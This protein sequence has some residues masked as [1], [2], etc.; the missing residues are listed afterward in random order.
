MANLTTTISKIQS[1]CSWIDCKELCK[2]IKPH[3]N[4]VPVT[5]LQILDNNGAEDALLA[6]RCWDYREWCLPIANIVEPCLHLSKCES[7]RNM[8]NTIRS[9]HCGGVTNGILDIEC[10]KAWDTVRHVD[11]AMERDAASSA[12]WAT[13]VTK[14]AAWDSA[15]D[16]ISAELAAERATGSGTVLWWRGMWL[17]NETLIRDF[18]NK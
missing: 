12:A 8:S 1:M 6:L 14:C 3:N 2:S 9:W 5:L 10:S 18:C 15:W 16:A 4:D 11:N 13:E 7:I 17:R